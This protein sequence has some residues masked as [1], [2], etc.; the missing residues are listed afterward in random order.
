MPAIR[1]GATYSVSLMML[2]F[3]GSFSMMDFLGKKTGGIFRTRHALT[4][5][6]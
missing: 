6:T 4:L 2:F 3:L 5:P 1:P